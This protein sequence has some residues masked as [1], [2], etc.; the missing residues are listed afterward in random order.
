MKILNRAKSVYSDEYFISDS[1]KFEKEQMYLRV[2][3]K[4]RECEQDT[5]AIHF[6]FMVHDDGTKIFASLQS[7]GKGGDYGTITWA[8]SW[9]EEDDPNYEDVKKYICVVNKDKIEW[10][11]AGK[12]H[13]DEFEYRIPSKIKGIQ[14]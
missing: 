8:K 10:F 4:W 6:P 11:E 13:G 14:E 5:Q 2:K 9:L 1:V 3:D 7:N 12:R